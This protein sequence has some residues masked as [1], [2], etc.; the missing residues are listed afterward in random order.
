MNERETWTGLLP[1][2]F[3]WLKRT[4]TCHKRRLMVPVG[5]M[6]FFTPVCLLIAYGDFLIMYAHGQF[7]FDV[8]RELFSKWP[9]FTMAITMTTITSL[10]AACSVL[11]A[12][13]DDGVQ[14]GVAYILMG[15]PLLTLLFWPGQNA[16]G[17]HGDGYAVGLAMF[18][19]MCVHGIGFHFVYTC[20]SSSR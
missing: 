6:F 3:R 19:L 8:S 5:F 1:D 15:I 20:V 14:V 17:M 9:W 10:A 4:M 11:S 16:F 7:T 13:E 12:K 2:F 18:L